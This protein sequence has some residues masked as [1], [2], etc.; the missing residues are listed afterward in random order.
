[1]FQLRI[2]GL[3]RLQSALI[4][5]IQTA[6]S[7]ERTLGYQGA[8]KYREALHDAVANQNFPK[9]YPELSKR[10]A[11]WKQKMVG[12][13]KFWELFGDMIASLNVW[14]GETD[15]AWASGIPDGVL[16][17]EGKSIGMY[18]GVNESKRALF[19]PVLEKL[20]DG[21]WKELT[22]AEM[23]LIAELWKG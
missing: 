10:Y 1:M 7:A 9:S 21:K 23:T 20:R 11:E 16:N 15:Q 17:R 2:E 6:T 18:A 12:H 13:T 8:V 14:Q 4:E 3:D 19:G 22:E 5:M